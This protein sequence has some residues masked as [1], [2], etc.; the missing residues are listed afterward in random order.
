IPVAAQRRQPPVAGAGQLSE[1]RGDSKGEVGAKEGDERHG[2]DDFF[3]PHLPTSSHR[4]IPTW[5][6]AN[7]GAGTSSRAHRRIRM[8]DP[9]RRACLALV[10]ESEQ[11][12]PL[13]KRARREEGELDVEQPLAVGE[14][15]VRLSALERAENLLHRALAC[16][17]VALE[18]EPELR[19]GR[20]LALI[21]GYLP[22]ATEARYLTQERLEEVGMEVAPRA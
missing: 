6:R 4:F 10:H 12:A 8:L 21:E 16:G 7:R 5:P 15:R 11:L 17:A 22:V 9:V 2:D 18:L 13:S 14:P 19:D 1:R 20:Q 3:Q